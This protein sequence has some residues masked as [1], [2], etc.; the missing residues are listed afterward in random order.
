MSAAP[1]V[2]VVMNCYNGEQYLEEAIAS[3]LAQT[4]ENWELIFWDNQSTDASAQIA[5]GANDPRVRYF[6]APEHTELGEARRQALEH[7]RGEWIGFLDT[8]DV[9][10]PNRLQVQLEAWGDSPQRDQIGLI[11]GR[12]I[13]F[14]SAVRGEAHDYFNNFA[15]I[16]NS[17]PGGKI[18]RDL[19]FQ[20]NFVPMPSVLIRTEA[21]HH[22][23]GFSSLYTHAPDYDMW[24]RIA[25]DYDAQPIDQ[26]LARYRWHETNASHARWQEDLTEQIAIL[27]HYLNQFPELDLRI[28]ALRRLLRLRRLQRRFPFLYS[29]LSKLYRIAR[30]A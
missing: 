15:E 4:Y 27:S 16:Q 14:G 7:A 18:L 3:V 12:V 13:V 2:S 11:Y 5:T 6:R 21:Y 28:R 22:C 23:G 25:G 20:G 1:L 29:I 19:L 30:A 24:C 17:L 26:F 10:M 9:W 8:D